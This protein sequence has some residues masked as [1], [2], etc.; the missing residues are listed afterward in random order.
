M[1]QDGSIIN[2]DWE[3]RTEREDSNTFSL[4]MPLFPQNLTSMVVNL[5]QLC[6]LGTRQCHGISYTISYRQFNLLNSLHLSDL[7]PHE[8]RQL[9]FLSSL[10]NVVPLRHHGSHKGQDFGWNTGTMHLKTGMTVHI[11]GLA[12]RLCRHVFVGDVCLTRRYTMGC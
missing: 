4:A 8:V 6:R 11:S 9:R 7:S 1:L 3:G 10:S 12:K 5:D 2:S